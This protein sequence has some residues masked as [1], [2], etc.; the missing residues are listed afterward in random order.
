MKGI[1]IDI[2]NINRIEKL[3]NHYQEKF[4]R[5]IFVPEEIEEAQ[6]KGHFY[7]SIAGKFAAKEAY[8]KATSSLVKQPIS[9]LDISVLS[10]SK[11]KPYIKKIGGPEVD[12][13]CQF[14]VSISHEKEYAVSVV[15]AF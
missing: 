15:V 1:G 3:C 4:L 13:L 8:I 9:F 5:K 2:V 14:Q 12:P 7:Q 10:D 11:G 6:K